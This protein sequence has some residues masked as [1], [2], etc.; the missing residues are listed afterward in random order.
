MPSPGVTLTS[1]PLRPF[2]RL[3]CSPLQARGHHRAKFDVGTGPGKVVGK[4]QLELV[5]SSRGGVE[6]TREHCCV[7]E[8]RRRSLCFS[9]VCSSSSRPTLGVHCAPPGAQAGRVP[10]RACDPM[11]PTWGF[12]QELSRG[13]DRALSL[14]QEPGHALSR[15][16]PLGRRAPPE[17][18]GRPRPRRQARQ[19]RGKGQARVSRGRQAPGQPGRS[20]PA[21]LDAARSSRGVLQALSVVGRTLGSRTPS[22]SVGATAAS[23]G[24][25]SGASEA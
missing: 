14:D 6:S 5:T 8:L 25:N 20:D 18:P 16:Q 9:R 17:E 4:V 21:R 12:R 23:S 24:P 11:R 15:G 1:P 13:R 7:H 10:T 3:V 22:V 19:G 2:S